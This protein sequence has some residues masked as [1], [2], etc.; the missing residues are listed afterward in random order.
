MQFLSDLQGLGLLI[1]GS[2]LLA[3]GLGWQHMRKALLAR[4]LIKLRAQLPRTDLTF[5]NQRPTRQRLEWRPR[6]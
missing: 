5:A 4:L 1:I 2:A 3:V 6:R